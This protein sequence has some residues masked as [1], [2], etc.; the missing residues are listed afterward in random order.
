MIAS[1]APRFKKA[2]DYVTMDVFGRPILLVRDKS[3]NIVSVLVRV[4][5][6]ANAI[7]ECVSQR[8]STSRV[9]SCD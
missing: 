1:F 4:Y 2:G 6:T 3:G 9:P 8:V 7:A 5:Q